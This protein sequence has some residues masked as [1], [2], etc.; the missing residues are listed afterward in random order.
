[1]LLASPIFTVLPLVTVVLPTVVLPVKV[2][3]PPTVCAPAVRTTVPS[4]ATVI[5]PLPLVAEIPDP[6]S[7][8][9]WLGDCVVPSS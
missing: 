2:L 1:L 7:N 4:T 5:L 3:S 8:V 9:F 6:K